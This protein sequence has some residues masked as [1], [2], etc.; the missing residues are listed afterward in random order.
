M[1]SNCVLI[2]TE[3]LNRLCYNQLEKPTDKGS[4]SILHKLVRNR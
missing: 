4:G 1:L 2:V 3:I